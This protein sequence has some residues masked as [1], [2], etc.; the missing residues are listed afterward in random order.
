MEPL[1]RLIG[2]WTT[3]ATHPMAPG[4]V[5]RGTA[6]L[7][8]MEGGHFLVM[9]ARND[10]PD[11]P[12]SLSI[13]GAMDADRA[14][15]VGGAPADLTMHYYDSR[16][17]FR[18]YRITLDDRAWRIWRDAPG[19]SQRFVGTFTDGGATIVGLWELSL[20]DTTWADDLRITFRRAASPG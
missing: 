16:G 5:V 15:P 6:D 13:L 4:T 11:F 10:H 8:W 9:R 17:V 18:E 2:H 14:K 12:D 19:F 20:D 7:A 3:E 1:D